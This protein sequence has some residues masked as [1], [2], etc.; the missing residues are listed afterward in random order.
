[1]REGR[2]DRVQ[3]PILAESF[4]EFARRCEPRLRHALVAVL[5]SD[6]GRDAVAEALAYGWENWSRIK[7]M[8]NPVGYLYG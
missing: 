5:G 2:G 4:T 8:E 6:A 7:T 3:L 1:M